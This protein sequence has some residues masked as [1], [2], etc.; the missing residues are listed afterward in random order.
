MTEQELAQYLSSLATVAGGGALLWLLMGL[1]VKIVPSLDTKPEAKFWI[2]FIGSFIIPVG[3]LAVKAALAGEQTTIAEWVTA[4]GTGY[5]I[6]QGVHRATSKV[7]AVIEEK[8]A[9][10]PVQERLDYY[11]GE[12]PVGKPVSLGHTPYIAPIAPVSGPYAEDDETDYT[13][14][15]DAIPLF[16]D[17][18]RGPS[19]GM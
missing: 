3:A 15:G 2:A 11:A 12:P 5:Q 1:L 17:E 8:K 9:Q 7:E 16:P 18:E 14:S 19:G 10:K 13:N 4:V 6:S